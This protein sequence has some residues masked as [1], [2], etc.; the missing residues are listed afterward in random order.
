ARRREILVAKK[1]II[2]CEE[3]DCSQA[4][5]G[6]FRELLEYRCTRRE[7]KL[8]VEDGDITRSQEVLNVIRRRA[9]LAAVRQKNA[10]CAFNGA[11]PGVD[12]GL[13]VRTLQLFRTCIV[14]RPQDDL[15]ATLPR[16]AIPYHALFRDDQNLLFKATANAPSRWFHTVGIVNCGLSPDE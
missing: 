2:L 8:P 4:S 3:H 7:I 9:G 1:L 12:L 14:G 6:S 15:T 13:R 16:N 11:Y 10:F 5:L